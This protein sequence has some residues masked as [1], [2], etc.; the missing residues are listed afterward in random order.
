[1]EQIDEQLR[2]LLAVVL[3][4]PKESKEYNRAINRLLILLQGLPEFKKYTRPGYPGYDLN[5]LNQTWKW[6]WQNVKNFK[7]RTSSIR[8]D[9]TN[10]IEGYLYWRIKDATLGKTSDSQ[11]SYSPNAVTYWNDKQEK[12]I[13]LERVTG[14]GRLVY[15]SS[16]SYVPNGIESLIEQVQ[17]QERQEVG[18]RLKRYV[19]TDPQ[20]KLRNCYPRH[21]PECNCQSV[22]IK[23]Y[24]KEPPDTLA[25]LAKEY[26]INYQT[27]NWHW[28]QRAI[29]LLRAIA[30]K[31]GYQT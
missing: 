20:R 9:L 16:K 18:L 27:L 7:P 5:A 2:Q 31:L 3:E 10:W 13:Y 29:P 14:H 25:A 24:F 15:R 22:T 23:R 11:T 26:R 17:D 6:F 1:M 8:Q 12:A 4:H 30:I 21:R 19:E 28:K